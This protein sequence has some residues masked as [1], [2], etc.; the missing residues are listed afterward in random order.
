MSKQ[1][2]YMYSVENLLLLPWHSS[3]LVDRVRDPDQIQSTGFGQS[4][5]TLYSDC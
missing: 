5:L 1:F 3:L 4:R 2:E